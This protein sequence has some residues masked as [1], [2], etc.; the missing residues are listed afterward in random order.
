MPG[1]SG[2]ITL[3]VGVAVLVGL[4]GTVVPVIPGPV[5]IGASIAVWAVVVNTTGGW[6][7]LA[8]VVLLLVAG[9]ALK[10]LTAG[11][12]ML[13]SGVPKRSILLAG[14]VALVA[15]V[16]IPVIGLLIGFVGALYLLERQRLGA[17]P[18]AKQSTITALKAVGIGILVE[19]TSALL[20]SGTWL[21]GVLNGAGG[22]TA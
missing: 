5:L 17:G 8:G 11:R 21:V 3:I 9:Q 19:L 20:A 7:L 15:G 18:G 1:L 22:V 10:Y 12:T 2:D 14:L 4:V 16:V 6:L 13:T